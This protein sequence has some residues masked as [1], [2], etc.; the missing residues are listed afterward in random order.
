MASGGDLDRARALLEH[1][2]ESPGRTT[3]ELRRRA[4]EGSDLP[5]DLAPLVAKIHRHAY[6]VTDED[7]DALRADHSE[8]ELFE[9]IVSASAGAAYARFRAG[10]KALEGIE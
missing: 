5:E 3:S 9:L 1:L 4:A 7:L 6:K 2:L 8:D 10:M